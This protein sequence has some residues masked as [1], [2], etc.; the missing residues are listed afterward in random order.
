MLYLYKKLPWMW[1]SKVCSQIEPKVSVPWQWNSVN[2]ASILL[3]KDVSN[4][5]AKTMFLLREITKIVLH[6]L[7]VIPR[8][9]AIF[10]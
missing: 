8:Q 9:A 10:M 2:E 1:F 7:I 5:F 4:S 6:Q 3:L